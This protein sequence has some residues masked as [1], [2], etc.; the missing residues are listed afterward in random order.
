MMRALSIVALL[1]VVVG[2]ARASGDHEMAAALQELKLAKDHLR[3]AG[4]DYGGHRRAAMDHVDQALKEIQQAI[5]YSRTGEGAAAPKG[6]HAPKE[7]A[8]SSDDD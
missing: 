5:Q 3:D 2:P 8:S 1:L 4:T 6:K 7:P